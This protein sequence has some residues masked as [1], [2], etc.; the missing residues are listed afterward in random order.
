MKAKFFKF[1]RGNKEDLHFK[2]VYKISF[3]SKNCYIGSTTTFFK[4]R[5]SN[6]YNRLSNLTHCNN[7]LTN[8]FKK[9]KGV[10]IFEIIEII[11]KE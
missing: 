9:Y 2:G 7:A 11:N 5:F 3:G 1:F 10:I 6:H 8:S 4:E